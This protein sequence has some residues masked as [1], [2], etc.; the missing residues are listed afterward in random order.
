LPNLVTGQLLGLEIDGILQVTNSFP[1]PN[2]A[3]E[4]ADADTDYQVEMLRCLREV[5][6]DHNTIGWYQSCY[7]GSFLNQSMI[8]SQYTYQQT[9]TPSIVII[10]DPFRANY[11]SLALR[12]FRLSPAFVSLYKE[13]RFTLEHILQNKVTYE[14]ILEELPI[15]IKNS[16]LV[17]SFLYTLPEL[18]APVV[19]NLNHESFL[20]KGL[21]ILLECTDEYNGEQGKLQGYLKSLSRAVLARKREGE[22][23]DP[24]AILKPA[25][26]PSRLDDL[27]LGGQILEYCNQLEQFAASAMTKLHLSQEIHK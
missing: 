16:A 20:E 5:N 15:E 17:N 24:K 10:Y 25:T 22:E 21:E 11:G 7:L 1:F 3:E 6:V 26:E 14:N 9:I 2:R 8:E 27:L 13:K 19:D 18:D 12:A 23:G 4:E